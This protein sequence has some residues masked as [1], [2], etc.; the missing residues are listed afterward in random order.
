[1]RHGAWILVILLAI[2]GVA[3]ADSL[4]GLPPVTP[5]GNADRGSIPDVY[6][7]D[8]EDL[9]PDRG[10]WKSALVGAE[11]GLAALEEMHPELDEASVLVE[12]L[13]GYYGLELD[14][15][16]LVLYAN[17]RV[18][19]DTT[20]QEAL[21]DHQQA[22]ALTAA[23]MDEGAVLREAVL[24]LSDEDLEQA[25]AGIPGFAVYRPAVDD[26]R[27][28]A[29]R[30][31][32][33]EAEMVLGLAGDNLWAAIDLNELP[34]PVERAFQALISEMPLPAIIGPDGEEVGLTF[35]NYGRFRASNDRKVRE[36]AVSAMFSTLRSFQNTLAA[37]LGGQAQ[38]DVTYARAR[39]YDTALEA[40]L[41]K[42][43]VDPAVYR[44][45]IATVRDHAPALQRYVELRRRVMDLEEVRIYDLYVPLVEA[46][47]RDMTY[48]EGAQVILDALGPLGEEYLA[49]VG[50]MIDPAN[51]GIDVYPSS[52]KE[53]GA[54]SSSVYGVHPFIKMNFQDSYD[55][56]ST[57]AHELGH[58]MHTQLTNQNQPYL[59]SRYTMMLAEVAS[60]CNEMLLSR[61]MLDRAQSK[62]ERA[63]LLSELAEGIRQTIYRQTLFAEFELALHELLEAGEPVTAAR[64]N[65]I[66]E[67]LIRFYYG[68]G[69]TVGPNDAV[70][71]AYIPHFYYK[72]YVYSYA[73]GMAS[74]IAIAERIADG[75]P[76]ARDAYLGMLKAGNSRPPVD[77]LRDGGADL[78]KPEAI[79][80]ALEYFDRVVAQLEELL[81]DE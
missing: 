72:Y 39:G 28:R 19:T 37:T 23:I 43:D 80:S 15:N 4:A 66:Y 79:A 62:Q 71:W 47:A 52:R 26:L 48:P 22:L 45:L 64:L 59:S 77:L 51:G 34:S 40:Y 10:A 9:Y 70:E 69:F 75:E 32:G 31:L 24:A 74:A 21:A 57:L 11:A 38:L 58:A 41:D 73:T 49:A 25:Y 13:D 6:K 53:S 36:R 7:W 61:Y 2:A 60:T 81:L 68:P 65:G 56:V 54:F 18:V 17:L 63:W 42:D 76:G 5:N 44:T 14:I 20:D 78:T 30:V 27:R 16:R 46:A 29:D 12:Y 1:M 55:D 3:G 67:E 50:E 8:L 33:A 35:S